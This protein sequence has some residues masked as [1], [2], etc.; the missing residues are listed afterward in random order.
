MF[1]HGLVALILV[2]LSTAQLT[3]GS[4][5]A[6]AG[7]GIG[8][9]V[10]VFNTASSGLV[11]RGP[12]PCDL[13]TGG[14]FDGATG[15]V[16]DGP[17][18]CSNFNRWRVQ[19]SDGL[20]G[21]SAENW[22]R[23]TQTP[24]V[25][26]LTMTSGGQSAQENQI[27]NLV[28][29][30]GGVVTVSF[31]AANSFD[32][33]GA[34]SAYSWKINGSQKSTSQ[35][36][37]FPLV[38][39]THQIFLTV[40]DNQ[41]LTG[42]VGASVVV[43]TQAPP[44][45]SAPTLSSPFSGQTGVSNTPLFAWTAVSGANKYWLTV[46][47]SAGTLPTD[48]N[49]SSCPGCSVSANVSATSYTHSSA[50]AHNTTYYWQ[51]QSFNDSV[52][53]V[54]QGQYSA[55]RSF[56]TGAVALPNLVPFGLSAP[57]SAKPGE[58]IS[59]GWT[60]RNDGSS[61][62]PSSSNT[63][64]L[65]GQGVDLVL[66]SHSNSSL[67]TNGTTH[68][69]NASGTLP[70]DLS[71]GS[72]Q[73]IVEVD[74]GDQVSES[75]ETDNEVSSP[76][77]VDSQIPVVD[78]LSVSSGSVSVGNS[79]TIFYSV[80][81]TGG[82][83]LKQVELWRA[84]DN[85]GSPGIWVKVDTKTAS[86]S[87]S[88]GSFVDSLSS[89]GGYWYGIHA[90]NNAG[91]W[92]PQGTAVKVTAILDS[93]TLT[94]FVRDGSTTGPVIVGALVTG[95]DANGSSFNQPTNF[96]GYVTITGA[97][98]TWSFTAA[99]S[100]Y[101]IKTW[102]EGITST[103]TNTAFLISLVVVPSAPLNLTATAGTASVFLSWNAPSSNGGATVTNYRIY[104]GTFS[105]GESLYTTISSSFTTFDNTANVSSGTTY[106]YKVAAVNSAGTGALSSGVNAT[107]Q[108]A[109]TVPSAPLNLTATAGTASVALSWSA[110]SSNG[111]ATVTNYRI[112]RGTFS[113]GESLYTTI[114]SAGTTFD[115]TANVSSGTTYYYKVAAVNS[116][117]TGALSSG[118]NAKPQLAVTVPSAPQG[119]T[120]TAGTTS[121]FLSWN[122]P[123]SNGGSAVTNYRI[124]RGTF[125]GG[126][127]FYT[128]ISSS[129]T[130]F[131]NTANVG[132]GTTYYYKVAAVNSV[133][134]GPLSNEASGTPVA[135]VTVP[136]APLNPTAS[137]ANTLF[138]YYMACRGSSQPPL[139]ARGG[140][141]EAFGLGNA[142]AYVG[143]SSQNTA[144]L[145]SLKK[146]GACP[147]TAEGLSPIQTYTVMFV[148]QGKGEIV[149]PAGQLIAQNRYVGGS[150]VTLEANP[151]QG[152][153]F[154]HWSGDLKG[155]KNPGI[156]TINSNLTGIAVFV[157]KSMDDVIQYAN[158]ADWELRELGRLVTLLSIGQR[159]REMS[160][161][162]LHLLDVAEA[163]GARI[164]NS[165][166][167][168]N[169]NFVTGKTK[170]D[171]ISDV[172][173]DM[174]IGATVHSLCLPLFALLGLPGALCEGVIFVVEAIPL[175]IPVV[176]EKMEL[177]DLG[178]VRL[179]TPGESEITIDYSKGSGQVFIRVDVFDSS[180]GRIVAILPVVDVSRT[181]SGVQQLAPRWDAAKIVFPAVDVMTVQI[182]SPVELRVVD[183]GG[184]ITGIVN[185]E[186]KR[187][188]LGSSYFDETVTIISNRQ[189][190]G[191]AA[192][193]I[194]VVGETDGEYGIVIRRRSRLGAEILEMTNLDILA[195]TVHEYNLGAPA[196]DS[197]HGQIILRID[198]DGD[199]TFD[200]ERVMSLNPI[201]PDGQ[202]IWLW[203]VV[204]AFVS[205]LASIVISVG[206]ARRV[207]R[208]PLPDAVD[209]TG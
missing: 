54:Q 157:P 196:S 53:P 36:F 99:K 59:L 84:P 115:N 197:R 124:Y 190:T 170:R 174:I 114:S 85:G 136:S 10:E 143:S 25:A 48:P 75:D 7:F 96:S 50:L 73:I 77:V 178:T 106:Y 141:Y 188:I 175:V 18:F 208:D 93:V 66:F 205:A 94:L 37:N 135:A 30:S 201:E 21:W 198:H 57:S 43:A 60:V 15:T 199:G 182:Q 122:A 113:G 172:A 81:D 55:Q 17:V 126:E 1:K 167:W 35:T 40:T 107:P 6:A 130:I 203:I 13:Q 46:A 39:G 150:I 200:E 68:Q 193:N 3:G 155:S 97:P 76:L 27:L 149:D 154:S 56:T 91:N 169:Y 171:Y 206:L 19:W 28:V 163:L 98:G 137:S 202:P 74:S 152:Y 26:R 194:T 83:G 11:V 123:S 9:T 148:S 29:L 31:S 105:G 192:Y 146:Q 127:S 186:I 2:V 156:V 89:V 140:M 120:A 132:S 159:T 80:S 65:V 103:G 158:L 51:V 92:A 165:D 118:V 72:Y 180:P 187:Q 117:G 44:L 100:G 49:A 88:S 119:L 191:S 147:E 32:P 12:S 168:L 78:S 133:G 181:L 52:S 129:F 185:G 45:L 134:E 95:Q 142:T 111:G 41:G 22:L 14:K 121:V 162:K 71:P 151:E 101:L 20:V 145:E 33:D 166:S 38:A 144:L 116:A 47:T 64:R 177:G 79:V 90:V 63:I 161:E 207:R 189:E 16:I 179:H 195:G 176:A 104:R 8:D 108:V 82:S 110:P 69:H 112:Y 102:S 86:G 109:V 5:A 34:I 184:L 87:S 61:S 125:S 67:S 153:V 164:E 24:P 160:E 23:K 70:A 4:G 42:S 173:S 128:T 58:T 139:S 138:E 183:E 204:A 209:E 62:A 131:D